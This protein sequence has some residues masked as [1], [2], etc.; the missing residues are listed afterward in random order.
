[1]GSMGVRGHHRAKPRFS[2][3]SSRPPMIGMRKTTTGSAFLMALSPYS[4]PGPNSVTCSQCVAP[5]M[6]DATR[7]L[8]PPARIASATMAISFPRTQMRNA[9]NPRTGRAIERRCRRSDAVLGRQAL[10][11]VESWRAGTAPELVARADLSV[12]TTPAYSQGGRWPYCGVPTRVLAPA[13]A[14]RPS[15]W[16]WCWPQLACPAFTMRWTS[17]ASPTG[18]AVTPPT[19]LSFRWLGRHHERGE[20]HQ[21]CAAQPEQALHAQAFSSVL[22][23]SELIIRLGAAALIGCA[24]GLDREIKGKP[25]GVRTLGLVALGSALAVMSSTDFVA[26]APSHDGSTSRAIQG[27]ITGIGFLGGGVILKDS[28]SGHVQGLTTAAAIWVTACMG[29][30]CGLGAWKAVWISAGLIFALL[31][32]GGRIDE[33]VHHRWQARE[34]DRP[35]QDRPL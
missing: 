35:D 31:I 11:P 23:F 32:V 19:H 6:R 33:I 7:P 13:S 16:R 9:A 1:M 20:L 24:I 18:T 12:M 4:A 26:T 29:F 10:S 17:M 2:R 5:P 21:I 14:P 30:V 3:P 25:T 22:G 15:A 28:S 8:V 34:K 27:V